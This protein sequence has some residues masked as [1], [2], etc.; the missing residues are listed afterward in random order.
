VQL[1][2]IEAQCLLHL[3]ITID[4]DIGI[5]PEFVE[6]FPLRFEQV[7]PAEAVGV[8]PAFPHLLQR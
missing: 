5:L 6:V 4:F 8:K 1:E 3:R 2:E 7:F